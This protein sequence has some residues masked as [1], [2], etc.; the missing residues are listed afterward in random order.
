[1]LCQALSR[2]CLV[3]CCLLNENLVEIADSPES[4]FLSMH[5]IIQEGFE[6]LNAYICRCVHTCDRHT[7]MHVFIHGVTT[8]CVMGSCIASCN[9]HRNLVPLYI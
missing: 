6:V 7:C 3:F 5:G 8:H 4:I 9:V 1:M 2:Y